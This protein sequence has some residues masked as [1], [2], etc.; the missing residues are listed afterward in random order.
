MGRVKTRLAAT[1]GDTKALNAYELLLQHTIKIAQELQ[2]DKSIFYSDYIEINDEGAEYFSI[3][4]FLQEGK[5]LGE[6]MQNA[7]SKCFSLGYEDICIIGSDCYELTQKHIEQ[8]FE[9]LLKNPIVLGP[10]FDGG[11]YL[12]GMNFMFK[13]LFLEKKWSTSTVFEDTIKNIEERGLQYALLEKLNDV[14]EE[15]D[16]PD[17]IRRLLQ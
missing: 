10:S 3:L 7:F 16:L 14:D 8:A 13:D 5:H 17:E 4:K 2:F 15:I 6:K 12:L 9:L 11:Y 1:L